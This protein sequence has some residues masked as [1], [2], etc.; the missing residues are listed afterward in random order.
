MFLVDRKIEERKIEGGIIFF[1]PS[2]FGYWALILTIM[3]NK[4][5][6]I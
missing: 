3:W 2:T 6:S 5:K 4:G 1:N